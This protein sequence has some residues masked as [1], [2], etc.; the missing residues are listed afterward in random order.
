MKDTEGE[1]ILVTGG[2][3]FIG[4]H[5]TEL[6]CDY[7]YTVVVVDDLRFGYE[8]FIDKRAEFFKIALEDSD[9]IEKI[10][11]GVDVVMH[12][13]ASSI[14]SLSYERPLEYFENNLTNGIKLLEAMKK[15]GVKKIIYSSTSSVYGE[16][17]KI[18]IEEDAPT[19][20]L[21]A[22]S[23]SKLAFEQALISYYHSFGIESVSLRYYNAYG[24]RDEQKPRTRAVPMWIEA[25]LN[26]KPIPWHWQGRQV[27][28]YIYVK[29]VAKA[30]LN[31]LNLKGIHCF[32]IGSGQGVYMHDVLKTLEKIVGRELKTRDMGER[33]GDPM[34]SF[35]DISKIKKV[36][37]WIPK[38]TLEEGLRETFE[39]YRNKKNEHG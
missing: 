37:G 26:N 35:A 27:R 36:A 14:I 22:Y 16:P 28:D 31:V 1:K 3:G 13:A 10:L 8:K 15:R 19:N 6:L 5:V 34:E 39:Y 24:P 23:A 30:H 4:S 21:N 12:L 9:T 11:E 38:V 2:A 33:K 7:G 25:I 20:P 29:D 18:P 17:Q 32:N